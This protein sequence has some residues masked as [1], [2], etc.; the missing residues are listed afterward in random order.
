MI[1]VWIMWDQG[2]IVSD[3]DGVGDAE[4]CEGGGEGRCVNGW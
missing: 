1:V 4:Y 3:Y 2:Q